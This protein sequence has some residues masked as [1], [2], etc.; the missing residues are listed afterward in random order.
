VVK[1]YPGVSL[2]KITLVVNGVLIVFYGEKDSISRP[3]CEVTGEQVRCGN[4]DLR[5]KPCRVD[6]KIQN[7]WGKKK[8]VATEERE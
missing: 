3:T 1:F 2:L 6:P 8:V 4:D 5:L 7:Q